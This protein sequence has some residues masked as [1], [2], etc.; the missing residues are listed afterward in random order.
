VYMMSRPARQT[1]CKNTRQAILREALIPDGFLLQQ[2]TQISVT[3]TIAW[4]IAAAF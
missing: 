2:K 3:K 1:N 4:D